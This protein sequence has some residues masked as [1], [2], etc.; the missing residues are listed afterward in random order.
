[1]P[2]QDDDSEVQIVV[3]C[4]QL[5]DTIELTP[6]KLW[7][8]REV[9]IESAQIPDINLYLKDGT[10]PEDITRKLWLSQPCTLSV[11]MCSNT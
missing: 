1:M 5:S 4:S 3:V 11:M 10:L 6:R 2:Q 8:H 9:A 7:L